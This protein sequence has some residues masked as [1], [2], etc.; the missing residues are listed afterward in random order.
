[1]KESKEFMLAQDLVL[2]LGIRNELRTEFA[3]NLVDEVNAKINK[4]LDN[5]IKNEEENN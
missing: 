5:I 1:M 3:R 4:E 2:V